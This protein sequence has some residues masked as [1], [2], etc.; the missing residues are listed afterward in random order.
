MKPPNEIMHLLRKK[1]IE[2]AGDAF[3]EGRA[4]EASAYRRA[5][6]ATTKDCFNAEVI[7]DNVSLLIRGTSNQ[8]YLTDWNSCQCDHGIKGRKKEDG[9]MRSM[10]WHIALVRAWI[11]AYIFAETQEEINYGDEQH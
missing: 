6:A 5:L 1:L 3:Q 7:D 9:E 10:C 11:A 2:S 4:Q 8:Y